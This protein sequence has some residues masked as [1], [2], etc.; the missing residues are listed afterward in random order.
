MEDIQICYIGDSFVGGVGDR[1]ILGW[2]GRLTMMSQTSRQEFTHYNLGIRGDT[3]SDIL[4]RWEIEARA[5][6]LPS[7]INCVVFSFGV[8]DTIMEYG[9]VK[10]SLVDSMKNAR[11]ILGRAKIRYNV[12]MIGPPAVDDDRHNLRIKAYDEAYATVCKM[13]KINYLSLFDKLEEKRGWKKEITSNDGVH[14]R[15]KGHELLAKYIYGWDG[16]WFR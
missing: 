8:N 2:T 14:P 16:W 6:L 3:S 4:K 7:S 15:E 5:R 10:V 1:E 9:K 11:E 13:L 12:I